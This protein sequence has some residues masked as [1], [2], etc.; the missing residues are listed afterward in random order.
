M[1]APTPAT[2]TS[3]PAEAVAEVL[4]I[5]QPFV[6]NGRHTLCRCKRGGWMTWLEHREHVAAAVVAA[7]D[8]PGREREAAAKALDEAADK[9]QWVY[10]L[11]CPPKRSDFNREEFGRGVFCAHRWWS[12]VLG[13]ELGRLRA[14]ASALREGRG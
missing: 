8:L 13:G 4:R 10:D 1:T 6:E 9:V 14:R 11:Q 3:P 7:L 5:H 2:P 12:I